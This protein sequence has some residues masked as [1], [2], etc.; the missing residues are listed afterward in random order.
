MNKRHH[1]FSEN[2]A[3]GRG[4]LNIGLLYPKVRNNIGGIFLLI[5]PEPK[6]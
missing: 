2:A 5:S 1:S 6:Y 4:Q 3:I